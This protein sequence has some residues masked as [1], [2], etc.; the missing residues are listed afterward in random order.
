EMSK[1]GGKV[2]EDFKVSI[3]RLP[4]KM[5]WSELE[6]QLSP[7]PDHFYRQFTPAHPELYPHSYSTLYLGIKGEKE[8]L[9]FAN[10]FNRYVFVDSAG[11]ES[12]ASVEFAPYQ[13]F[14]KSSKDEIG[15]DS[16]IA[17]IES[18]PAYLAFLAELEKEDKAMVTIEDQL[19]EAEEKEKAK[20]AGAEDFVVT[21]LVKF[22]FE[23]YNKRG[24][25]D[26]IRRGVMRGGRGM[27]RG[28][29]K[30]PPFDRREKEQK[31]G[32]EKKPF[33]R[34]GSG[35]GHRGREER[36][37]EEEPKREKK[38]RREKNDDTVET[39]NPKVRDLLKNGGQ[40]DEKTEGSERPERTDRPKRTPPNRQKR[41]EKMKEKGIRP[42]RPIY[43]PGQRKKTEEK[44]ES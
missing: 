40:K 30:P 33:G 27:D 1:E 13:K 32:Y 23:Q 18:D 29:R 36:E 38:E 22:F 14:P 34:P 28:G 6:E 20:M 15:A 42:E 21:P 44:K 24:G 43:T 3:R 25:F 4:S 39:L 41:D 12:R 9:E 35:G 11:N 2:K 26:S 37:K 5:A 10:R 19:K 7:L 31:N 16:K 8:V 17:T